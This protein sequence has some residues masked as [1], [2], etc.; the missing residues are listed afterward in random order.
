MHNR[1]TRVVQNYRQK[2]PRTVAG[3]SR[4]RPSYWAVLLVPRLRGT[5]GG[6][7]K[8][9]AQLSPTPTRG[10]TLQKQYDKVVCLVG[11]VRVGT[12]KIIKKKT[13]YEITNVIA[14][15][16]NK[17]KRPTIKHPTIQ[18]HF[19]DPGSRP[20]NAGLLLFLRVVFIFLAPFSVFNFVPP[21]CPSPRKVDFPTEP[22]R[23]FTLGPQTRS[24]LPVSSISKALFP[25]KSHGHPHRSVA[26]VVND[27][28]GPSQ[29]ARNL[30][31]NSTPNTTSACL[32]RL[33]CSSPGCPARPGVDC[34]LPPP[35][36][37]AA[38]CTRETRPQRPAASPPTRF[39]RS[40]EPYDRTYRPGKQQLAIPYQMPSRQ[41]ASRQ[42]RARWRTNSPPR[43]ARWP[44]RPCP[45]SGRATW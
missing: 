17:K 18:Q 31:G 14:L 12:Q 1:A 26:A 4:R 13:A 11:T 3:S 9:M 21:P 16:L 6:P 28:D 43:P 44:R 10:G 22:R 15:L 37:P 7:P 41:L 42:F 8:R 20:F 39:A 2:S 45:R 19:P 38:C 33:F 34:P 36:T 27:C 29:L 32:L 40:I 24:P 5:A 23:N 25:P 35:P 30:T